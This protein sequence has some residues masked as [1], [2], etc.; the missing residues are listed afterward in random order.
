M[1]NMNVCGLLLIGLALFVIRNWYGGKR[2]NSNTPNSQ[3]HIVYLNSGKRYKNYKVLWKL[4][5][6][7][8]R[9]EQMDYVMELKIVQGFAINKNF[10]T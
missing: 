2:K 4:L 8:N 9:V 6:F 5:Y 10:S 7:E 1:D 3:F